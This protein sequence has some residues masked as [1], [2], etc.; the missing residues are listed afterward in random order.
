MVAVMIALAEVAPYA[1]P[2]L[3]FLPLRH[4][5]RPGGRGSAEGDSESISSSLAFLAASVSSPVGC[6]GPP[7]SGSGSVAWLALAAPTLLPRSAE[8]AW[9]VAMT[10]LAVPAA[11]SSSDWSSS[12]KAAG[13][14]AAL[15]KSSR[16]ITGSALSQESP[17]RFK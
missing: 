11:F 15:L 6:S 5:E 2:L 17:M 4:L 12:T 8:V 3:R 14:V 10:V 13:S 1:R 16:C 7:W 9:G